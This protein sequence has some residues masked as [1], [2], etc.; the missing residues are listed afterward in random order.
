MHKQTSSATLLRL[1]DKIMEHS[2]AMLRQVANAAPAIVAAERVCEQL[3]GQGIG[4]FISDTIDATSCSVCVSCNS[5][6]LSSITDALTTLGYSF[7]TTE[8]H[9][10]Q[11]FHLATLEVSA[12]DQLVHVA[13]LYELPAAQAK[14]AA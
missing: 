1:Q 11:H 14:E 6:R 12:G 9:T 13:T 8:Q 4:A 3:H 5:N 2:M 10:T 7:R